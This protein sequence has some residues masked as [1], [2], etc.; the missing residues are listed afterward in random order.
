VF[1]APTVVVASIAVLVLI[2]I[3][4]SRLGD[5]IGDWISLLFAFSPARLTPPAE[6]AGYV[7]PGGEGAKYW[8][9]VTHA[10][11]HADWL[12]LIVNSVWMLAFGSVVARHLGAMRFIVFSLFCA[13]AGALTS[14]VVYWG[15]LSLMIGAS[16]AVS[17]Q[18]GAA[19]RIMFAGGPRLSL[20]S[21]RAAERVRPLSLVDTFRHK[22]AM[23]FIAIWMTVN[24]IFGL[25]GIGAPGDV[26][27]IAWEAH[28]GGFAAGLL[29]FGLFSRHDVA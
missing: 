3:V 10:F 15:T 28:A 9:F 21:A 16:G 8:T 18:M 20:P 7:L 23:M 4:R 5:D 29:L 14:Q 22:R 11:L 24:V 27:R 2:H 17:G 25:T 12:H 26:S 6:F 13:A 19:I 1:N